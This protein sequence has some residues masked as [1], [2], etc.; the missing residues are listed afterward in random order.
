MRIPKSVKLAC[1][2]GNEAIRRSILISSKLTELEKGLI[3]EKEFTKFCE[4]LD[5]IPYPT[6][7]N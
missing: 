2:R 3:S 6:I 4:A 1:K 7:I 5:A